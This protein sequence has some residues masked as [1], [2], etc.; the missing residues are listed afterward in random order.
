M[1]LHDAVVISDRAH[2]GQVD[3]LGDPYRWHVAR[4]MHRFD[5]DDLEAKMAAALHDVVEDTDVTLE[6]LREAGCPDL[7]LKAVD[8]LTKRDGEDY[9]SFIRRVSAN[10]LARRVKA[11]DLCDNSDED[12]LARLPADVAGRLRANY[13]KAISDLGV[14]DQVSEWRKLDQVNSAVTALVIGGSP[15]EFDRL[16]AL[17]DAD[18]SFKCSACESTAGRLTLVGESLLVTGF[19]GT[20][21]HRVARRSLAAAREHIGTGALESLRAINPEYAPFWCARCKKVWCHEHWRTEV[22]LDDGF[23][24]ATYGTCSAGHRQKLDD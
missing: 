20:A 11:A 7:V 22:L 2:E 24:D 23:Y 14:A 13:A 19:N 17:A 1:D 21:Q 15:E 16:V 18:A 3:K 5:D 4:V 6:D 8:A 12:R 10:P 9:D